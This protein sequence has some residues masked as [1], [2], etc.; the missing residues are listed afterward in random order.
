MPDTVS[1]TQI[2]LL[3]GVNLIALIGGIGKGL[4]VLISVRDEL[5]DMRINIGAKDPPSG[6]L[7]DVSGLQRESR[8]HRDSLIEI[9]TEMGLRHPGGRT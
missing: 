9:T 5:R 7:G 1:S 2:Y 3:F 6:L 8:H 4:S